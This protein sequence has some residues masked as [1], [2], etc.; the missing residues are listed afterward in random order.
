MYRKLSHSLSKYLHGKMGYQLYRLLADSY[1][2]MR[3]RT[4][5]DV[6]IRDENRRK[7]A[8]AIED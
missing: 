4:N 2:R 6:R 3:E 8:A 1:S 5:E 7:A